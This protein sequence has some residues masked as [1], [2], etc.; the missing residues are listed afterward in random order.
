MDKEINNVKEVL[1]EVQ[2]TAKKDKVETEN[3]FEKVNSEIMHLKNK[4]SEWDGSTRS[5]RERN[6]QNNPNL[7]QTTLNANSNSGVGN[8]PAVTEGRI[9][10]RGHDNNPVLCNV[11]PITTSGL[12]NSELILP[13]YDEDASVNPVFHLKQLDEYIRLKC[14]PEA[15]QLM[16]ACKS[17]VGKDS[18]NWAVTVGQEL[19]NYESFKKAFLS[20]W[21]STAQK[22]RMR[23]NSYQG[24]Y[25]KQAGLTLSGHFLKYALGTTYL[26]PSLSPEE[27]IDA[28]RYHF[29]ISVQRAILCTRPKTI[30]EVV[31]LLKGIETIEGQESYHS[32]PPPHSNFGRN[33]YRNEQNSRENGRNRGQQYARNTQYQRQYAG[34]SPSRQQGRRDGY[35]GGEREDERGRRKRRIEEPEEQ[36]YHV[37]AERRGLA[38]PR[39]GERQPAGN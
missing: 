9:S 17:V 12:N 3:R 15:Y 23:C 22:N 37:S 33:N 1:V 4:F 16:V 29:P 28:I 6:I 31:E 7:V 34:N 20:T 36:G 5:L 19:T 8:N 39:E 18:K 11:N 10:D 25:D 35:E 13:L 38:P 26:E 14:V 24:K 32:T 27:V 2:E 30:G 21:W